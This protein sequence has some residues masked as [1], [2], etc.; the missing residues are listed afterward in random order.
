LPKHEL[1][2]RNFGRPA[3]EVGSHQRSADYT[4][5]DDPLYAFNPDT[6]LC[7]FGFN[8]SFAGKEGLEKFKADYEKFIDDYTA[9]YPRDDTKAKPRFL[10]VSPTAFETTY[11]SFLPDAKKMNENLKLYTSAIKEVAEKRK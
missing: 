5:L 11:D 4:K 9:R 2:V 3:E 6:F 8:E 7:F 1:V 10:L